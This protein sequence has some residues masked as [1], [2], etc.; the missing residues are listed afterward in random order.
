ME[1]LDEPVARIYAATG[2]GRRPA[3]LATAVVA[4]LEAEIVRRGWPVGTVI[5][6]E[7][8]LLDRFGV[9]PPVL[10]Q[11]VGILERE[12]V[13]RMRRGPGG[14]L[15]VLAPDESSVGNA[16]TMFLEYLRVAPELVSEARSAIEIA[17]IELA[18][19]RIGEDDIAPLR[20]IVAAEPEVPTLENRRGLVEV[21][22]AIADLSGNPVLALFVRILHTLIE[23]RAPTF[24]DPLDEN[25]AAAYR[26]VHDEHAAI[27]EALAAGDA[28]LARLRMV[29]HLEHATWLAREQRQPGA[30]RAAGSAR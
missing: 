4:E 15:L 26:R 1:Q 12:Q 18:A 21:H 14:G 20:A 29:R 5:A 16:V 22:L 3:T 8:E 23:E 11:A 24:P 25:L 6:T 17:C 27:V 28:S 30:G 9:S 2:A 7:A 19:Q 13:A 10:R